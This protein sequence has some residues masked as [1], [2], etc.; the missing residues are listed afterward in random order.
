MVARVLPRA[1]R[2]RARPAGGHRCADVSHRALS[3]LV[4]AARPRE[5][6]S[7]YIESRVEPDVL[8]ELRGRGHDIVDAGAWSFG[9]L[10]AVGRDPDTQMLSA[11]ANPRGGARIR[12]QSLERSR[13]ALDGSSAPMR[14]ISGFSDCAARLRMDDALAALLVASPG[15]GPP[16][17]PNLSPRVSITPLGRDVPGARQPRRDRSEHRDIQQQHEHGVR[18]TRKRRRILYSPDPE[19]TE[20]VD[21]VTGVRNREPL[22]D[23][24]HDVTS[25]PAQEAE[26]RRLDDLAYAKAESDGQAR[27]AGTASRGRARTSPRTQRSGSRQRSPLRSWSRRIGDRLAVDEAQPR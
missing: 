8:D 15:S 27:T 4:R 10:C 12:N 26:D 21:G 9:P 11:A 3:Q 13:K 18:G 22:L 2:L 19:R 24:L 6:G 20:R 17:S 23:L 5:P 16:G 25:E 7:L 1:R 14:P